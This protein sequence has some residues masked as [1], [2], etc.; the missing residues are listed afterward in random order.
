VATGALVG[1]PG[2]DGR[3]VLFNQHVRLGVCPGLGAKVDWLACRPA[4]N[5]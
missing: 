3:L 1:G 2:N 4:G 5:G